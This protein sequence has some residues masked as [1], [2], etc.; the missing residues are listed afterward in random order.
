MNHLKST[1]DVLRV[2]KSCDEEYLGIV[3]KIRLQSSKK[4]KF[5]FGTCTLLSPQG[6]QTGD[7]VVENTYRGAFFGQYNISKKLNL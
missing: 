6:S 1:R 4:K 7:P 5:F 3:L 2:N